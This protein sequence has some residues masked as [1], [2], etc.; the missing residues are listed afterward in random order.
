MQPIP[1]FRIAPPQF[2]DAQIFQENDLKRRVEACL[3]SRL[4][5]HVAGVEIT[6]L[7]RTVVFRG[8]SLTEEE[9]RLCN[10]CCRHVP[11]VL[12]VMEKSVHGSIGKSR[13]TGR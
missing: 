6:V 1:D 5:E 13:E 7:G 2:A 9:R 8:D 12:R 11:G 3:T 4:P 10:E